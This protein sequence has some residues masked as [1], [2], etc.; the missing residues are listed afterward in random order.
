[1]TIR[2]PRALPA[3]AAPFTAR[4][5]A[6]VPP[7]VKTISRGR[8]AEVARPAARGPR[9]GQS[10]AA[11]AEGMRRRRVA[12]RARRGTAASPRAPRDAAASSRRGRGRSAW[13]ASGADCTADDRGRPCACRREPGA[14][15]RGRARRRHEPGTRPAPVFFDPVTDDISPAAPARPDGPARA[16]GCWATRR[17]IS[18]ACFPPLPLPTPPSRISSPRDLAPTPSASSS[19]RMPPAD[20]RGSATC[21]CRP[22]SP[23]RAW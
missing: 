9:R 1:M 21:A 18:W 23:G 14:R 4:L 8:A 17:T 12:E 5:F 11:P 13:L 20:R 3:Q 7:E 22:S 10:R 2:L 15:A 16:A 19:A 6:S